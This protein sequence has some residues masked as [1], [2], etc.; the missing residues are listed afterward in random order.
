MDGERVQAQ[1]GAAVIYRVWIPGRFSLTNK[2][3]S[4]LRASEKYHGKKPKGWVDLFAQE[5]LAIRL[6]ARVAINQSSVPVIW[7]DGE[8]CALVFGVFEHRRHDP[9]AWYLLA[10]AVVD[11]FADAGV[12]GQDRSEVWGTGGRVLQSLGEELWWVR[13]HFGVE[14]HAPDGPGVLVRLSLFERPV[15][16]FGRA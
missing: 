4:N 13:E 2:M 6:A 10:K 1:G 7:K 5:T 15:G 16:R 3:L 8:V 9:D 12:I 11:G 14:E